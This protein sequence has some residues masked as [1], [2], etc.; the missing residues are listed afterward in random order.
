MYRHLT[1]RCIV[2][3]SVVYSIMACD[4]RSADIGSE[5]FVSDS[6]VRYIPLICSL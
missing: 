5:I 3:I 1:H 2:K 4:K 6:H